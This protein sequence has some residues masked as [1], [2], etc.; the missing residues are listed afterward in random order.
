MLARPEMGK[1][2]GETTLATEQE[3]KEGVR[4]NPEERGPVPAIPVPPRS[5]HASPAQSLR[6]LVTAEVET[7]VILCPVPVCPPQFR[8]HPA[9]L[10]PGMEQP[11]GV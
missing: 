11:P 5:F 4:G 6:S 2:G 1:D 7:P 3:S 8:D 9:C 10:S